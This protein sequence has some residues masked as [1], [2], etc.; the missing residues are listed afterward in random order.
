MSQHSESGL[1]EAPTTTT[2]DPGDPGPTFR[3]GNASKAAESIAPL[4]DRPRRAGKKDSGKE[5]FNC[6]IK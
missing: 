5:W 6:I 3:I 2:A 4:V 1:S